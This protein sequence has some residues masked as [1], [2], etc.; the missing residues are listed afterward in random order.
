MGT[1]WKDNQEVADGF[2]AYDDLPERVIGYPTVFDRLRLGDPGVGRVLD[3]GCGPGKVALRAAESRDV[4]VVAVDISA[5]MLGIARERRSHPRIRHHLIDGG[6]LPFL[7][8]GSVDAAMSCYVFINIGDPG[9]IRAIAAEIHRVLRPG[10]R[11]CVLD[12][13]PDTTGI[14]FSTFCSGEPGRRYAPGERR[15]VRLHH[16]PGGVLDLA[17]HHWPREFYTDVF[18]GAGFASVTAEAPLLGDVPDPGGPGPLLGAGA[19][20]ADHPPFLIVTGVKE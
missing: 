8:D 11:Y 9:T 2:E 20:E 7:A 15:P 13:H 6:R 10:G 5:W 17:D 1:E 18:T 14:R 3:Y 4:D 19:A 16:R 12:T